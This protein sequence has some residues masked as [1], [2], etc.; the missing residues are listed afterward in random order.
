MIPYDCH[1]PDAGLSGIMIVN[2]TTIYLR[3]IVGRDIKYAPTVVSEAREHQKSLSLLPRPFI[4]INGTRSTIHATVW[5]VVFQ[6]SVILVRMSHDQPSDEI[7]AAL[8]AIELLL[9]DE[10]EE[11]TV[12]PADRRGWRD[13]A[14]LATAN[15]APAQTPVRPSWRTIERLRGRSR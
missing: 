12:D 1:E 4:Y 11:T 8:A 14:R 10:A 7:A 6:P 3:I 2:C 9:A 5:R 13:S 15:L